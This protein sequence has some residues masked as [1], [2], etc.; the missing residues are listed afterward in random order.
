MQENEK[1]LQLKRHKSIA[2]GLF[3]LM[4]V[5]FLLCIYLQ[6]NIAGSWLGYVKAFA[7]AAMVGALA[8]WFAVT[9]LFHHPMGLPIPH[10]NLIENSKK[11]IG[12]NLG[13]FVV[14]NFLT[15]KNIRPY[16]NKIK[17]ASFVGGWLQKEHNKNLIIKEGCFLL[18]DIVNKLEDDKMATF[19]AEKGAEM[20]KSI[21]LARLSA[22]AL[23]YLYDNNE[24]EKLI[25]LLAEKIKGF[26]AENE[27][28][29]KEK[30]HEESYFFI[31]G[32]VDRKLAEKITKGLV[33]YFDDIE[34]D[35][36]HR[37]R[38]EI[39][40]QIKIF[41]HDLNN[42]EQWQQKLQGIV[43]EFIST[44]KLKEYAVAAWQNIKRSLLQELQTDDSSLKKYLSKSLQ[45]L[46][47]S[48]SADEALQQKIDGW[49]RHTAYR[50][51][52][53]NSKEAGTLISNTI[54][55]W[56][57]RELSQKLE[58]EVGKD[59]QFIRINGTLVGGLVGLLLY[60][61]TKLFG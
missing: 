55:N 2:T 51:I 29:V 27:E 6:K 52:L 22:N 23:Q 47:E 9:A 41:I 49:L 46:S 48:L 28:L 36:Q 58:L 42:G 33:R 10:T 12:D 19:L 14:D 43:E 30:V 35:K 31:P 34:Q 54:G 61:I 21:P 60:I 50:F 17:L 18:A 40:A 39:N 15:A 5:I 32:F 7:E 8:D 59:L 1:Y 20:M 13:N 37:V 25:T 16:I 26:I 57:G 4:A 53:K 44:N 24:Q 45:N 3:I 38:E 11:R 56:Q